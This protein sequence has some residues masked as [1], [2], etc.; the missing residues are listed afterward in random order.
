MFYV[1]GE[2][3]PKLKTD[4][5]DSRP[6]CTEKPSEIN[7]LNLGEVTLILASVCKQLILSNLAYF[8]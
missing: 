7:P 1:P 2:I 6:F 5:N 4:K 8:L 3:L